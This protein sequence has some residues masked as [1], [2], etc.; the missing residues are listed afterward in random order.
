MPSRVLLVWIAA[1]APCEYTRAWDGS[2][3]VPAWSTCASLQLGRGFVLAPVE[4]ARN[5]TVAGEQLEFRLSLALDGCSS[6]S[7]NTGRSAFPSTTSP[8]TWSCLTLACRL[9]VSSPGAPAV[10]M[11]QIRT[12]SQLVCVSRQWAVW[13]SRETVNTWSPSSQFIHEIYS[14]KCKEIISSC[15]GISSCL[16][17]FTSK[18]STFFLRLFQVYKKYLS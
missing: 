16:I 12:A 11:C 9:L 6:G 2:A 14:N 3:Q 10:E 13:F 7:H 1:H 17:C 5:P 15:A 4:R 18:F 8:W